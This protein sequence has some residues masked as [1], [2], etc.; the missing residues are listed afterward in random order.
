MALT[1]RD[2]QRQL[3]SI[4]FGD[5]E[6]ET[7]LYAVQLSDPLVVQT[8]AVVL[9]SDLTGEPESVAFLKVPSQVANFVKTVDSWILDQAIAHK[10][11]WFKNAEVSDDTLRGS[12]KC[13]LKEEG[14]GGILK[15]RIGDNLTCF[16]SDKSVV[17]A[18]DIHVGTQ[19]RCVL[20]LGKVSFGRH[21][22]G[23]IFRVSQI[24]VLPDCLIDDAESVMETDEDFL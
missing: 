6:K 20:T 8:P 14:T 9:A 17:D 7:R 19:I 22:F 12:F 11:D 15:V 1:L 5:L 16:G 24:R 13:F 23:A 3:D 18:T 10:A 2:A 4:S 21:E